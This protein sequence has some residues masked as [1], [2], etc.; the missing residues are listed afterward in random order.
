MNRT[1]RKYPKKFNASAVRMFKLLGLLYQ[2]DTKVEDVV[3]LFNDGS[4]QRETN[5]IHVSLCK[6]LNT[7]KILGIRVEKHKEQ[8]EAFNLPYTYN[9][10]QNELETIQK[11]KQCSELILVG[12]S[13]E[14]FDKFLKALETRY[15]D[16]TIKIAK[17]LNETDLLDF[18]FYFKSMKEQLGEC[19]K[20]ISDNQ[21]LDI[22]Y[23]QKDGQERRVSGRPL[24]IVFGKRSAFLRLYNHKDSQVY[25]IALKSILSIIQ[26]P[27]K[28]G[29]Q[30]THTT[31]IVFKLHGRLAENY[32]LKENEICKGK[33]SDGSL[34]I[35]NQNE[36]ITMLLH[37][38]M[39]Y[40]KNC[41][42]CTPHSVKEQMKELLD[43]TIAN[44]S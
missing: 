27:Q 12:K 32:Q 6:Y 44:Y 8:Y 2:G 35:I 37:R 17:L 7:L 21:I 38:L 5:S 28:S 43:K 19:E 24:E 30:M 18:S 20:Y 39:R 3:N 1:K 16:N 25:E 42:V 31:S 4:K 33:D 29:T 9:F 40:G 11:F 14:S 26:S 13:K 36:D 10:S 23:T 22:L 41:T 15:D 34:I